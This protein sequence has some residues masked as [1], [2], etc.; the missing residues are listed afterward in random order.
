MKDFDSLSQAVDYLTNEGFTE[1]FK[2][3]EKFIP[4]VLAALTDD[5]TTRDLKGWSEQNAIPFL[6]MSLPL[7]DTAYQNFP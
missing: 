6:D 7:G 3:E 5:E 2:A 1:D 4:F